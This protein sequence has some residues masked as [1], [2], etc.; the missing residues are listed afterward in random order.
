MKPLKSIVAYIP[1]FEDS[2]NDMLLVSHTKENYMAAK[3]VECYLKSVIDKILSEKDAEIA[4]LKEERRWRKFSDEKPKSVRKKYIVGSSR[5]GFMDCDTWK[6][7]PDGHWGFSFYDYGITNWMPF[8][9][10][11]KEEK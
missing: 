1:S 6:K 10:A 9:E 4:R 8:P 7:L 5:S 2:H 11:P 3:Q